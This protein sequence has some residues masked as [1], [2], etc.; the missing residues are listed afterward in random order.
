MPP[1]RRRTGAEN[2]RPLQHRKRR[3]PFVAS[4]LWLG[5]VAISVPARAETPSPVQPPKLVRSVQ[6]EYPEEARRAALSGTVRL[7]LVIGIDGA[8]S[9]AYVLRRAGHGFDESALRAARQLRFEPALLDGRPAAVRIEYEIAFTLPAPGAA[10]APY[11][12]TVRAVPASAPRLDI[13]SDVSV[14]TEDRTPRAGETVEQLLSELPGVT[15]TRMGGIG[16]VA[17]ISLRGSTW[18]QVNVYV[19]GV[20]LNSGVGGGVDLSTLPIGDIERIE[21]YRGSSP[22]A[23][24]SSALGGVVSITTRSP[25]TTGGSVEVGAGSFDTESVGASGSL[26]SDKVRLYAGVHYLN[27]VG[28][29]FFTSDNGLPFDKSQD[30][31]VERTNNAVSQVDGVLRLVVPLGNERELQVSALAFNCA[32]GLP[33]FGSIRQTH[34]T[35]LG[36]LRLDGS[37]LYDSRADLGLGGRL[38][39]QAYTLY[40]DLR[41]RDPLAEI[42]IVPQDTN[43]TTWDAGA[44]VRLVRS[45]LPWLRLSGVLELREEVFLP[46]DAD[47]HP[48]YGATS[49][50]TFGGAGAEADAWWEAARLHVI[51]SLRVEGIDDERSGRNFSQQELRTTTHVSQVA[52]TGRLALVEQVTDRVSVRANG[53]RYVRF[54]SV[55]ELFGDSGFILGNPALLPES[56][57]NADVGTRVRV[58]GG[59]FGATLDGSVFAS[60]VS[61]LIQLQQDAYGRASAVNIGRA[62][63]LGTEATADVRLTEFARLKIDG[64]FIDPRDVSDTALGQHAPL[65]TNQPRFHVYG[66]PEG[67]L[68][69]GSAL[70]LG[71]YADADFTDGNYLDPANLVALPPRVFLGAGL[72]AEVR[73]PHTGLLV[74]ASGQNLADVHAFDFAGFPLPSRS[75]FISARCT[76]PQEKTL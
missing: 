21:V 49:T 51:P 24:G 75:F 58:G 47:A 60:F 22:I 56:G 40:G 76:F 61:D 71:A 46:Y 31:T 27:S 19:D 53:G 4:S 23:F 55:Y 68:P 73:L 62:R 72:F 1:L 54:P 34:D 26:V 35:T 10:P 29:F 44:T 8:V 70:I 65:L 32:Q 30:H 2:A 11:E 43:D 3:L 74:A 15:V 13:A 9:E 45:V 5:L 39:V 14:I 59:R 64:T 16:S 63:V 37:V 6:A 7:Q 20:Q 66:R 17:Q 67:R 36:T 48:A 38:Q 69:I 33:G 42:S 57:W 18:N 12:S 50:R 25:Q 28:N 52:P 41:F